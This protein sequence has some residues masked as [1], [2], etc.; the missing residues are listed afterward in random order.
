MKIIVK[1]P[2]TVAWIAVASTMLAC[3]LGGAGETQDLQESSPATAAVE[4]VPLMKPSPTPG[5]VPT[6]TVM[7]TSVP[8]EA[9]APDQGSTPASTPPGGG[10][11]TASAEVITMAQFVSSDG[12]FHVIGTIVNNGDLPIS[13]MEVSYDVLDQSGVVMDTIKGYPGYYLLFPGEITAFDANFV[14]PFPREVGDVQVR[15]EGDAM[16][17][18][19]LN[20][21]GFL[22]SFTHEFEVVRVE[23]R[24]PD[25]G[26]YEVVGEV[27]NN[28]GQSVTH[29]LITVMLFDSA[30]NLLGAV[31]H[32]T[33]D[34]YVIGE[35]ILLA[36]GE[37]TTF[38]GWFGSLAE[39]GDVARIEVGFEGEKTE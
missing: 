28:S 13:S 14:D 24:P 21:N 6:E 36:P 17:L 8:T 35:G 7:P 26:D 29:V 20:Q 16:S 30:D 31:T 23:G 4:S 5:E 3:Q 15:L 39:G 2:V 12:V 33:P 25:I 34:K 1:N 18:A 9:P 11:N 38:K 37:T 19:E 10:G 27:K 22:S 32:I